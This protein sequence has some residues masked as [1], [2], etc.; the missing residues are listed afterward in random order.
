M[1]KSYDNLMKGFEITAFTCD[2]QMKR[3][4]LGDTNGHVKGFNMSTGDY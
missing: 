1:K 3:F 2:K 4:Y